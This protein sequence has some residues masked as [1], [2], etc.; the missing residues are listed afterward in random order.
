M[1]LSNFVI[2]IQHLKLKKYQLHF[3]A[4]EGFDLYFQYY[5][6]FTYAIFLIKNIKGDD[7]S[8]HMHKIY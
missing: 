8:I 7:F 5:K 2:V 6:I 3:L 1:F 4:L